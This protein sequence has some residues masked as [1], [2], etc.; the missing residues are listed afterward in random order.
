MSTLFEKRKSPNRKGLGEVFRQEKGS[1]PL[2]E[3]TKFLWEYG[4]SRTARS[5][6]SRLTFRCRKGSRH[7]N[8][9]YTTKRRFVKTFHKTDENKNVPEIKPLGALP[10]S[11]SKETHGGC[12]FYPAYGLLYHKKT[13]CQPIL[14][15]KGRHLAVLNTRCVTVDPFAMCIAMIP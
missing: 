9:Y 4:S 6:Q 8:R 5:E 1:S 2:A 11:V 10:E 13:V 7:L 14:Q 3:K 12:R 15:K